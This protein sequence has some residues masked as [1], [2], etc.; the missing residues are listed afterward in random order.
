[1]AARRKG[2]S[3]RAPRKPADP[4][5]NYAR[6]VKGGKIL[7]G[8]PVHLA[9]E[10][11]LR[12]LKRKDLV[13]RPGRGLLV[14]EFFRDMLVLEDGS[15][16]DLLDFQQ[17][18][19]G[20]VFGWYS[21]DGTRRFRTAYVE[22]GKGSGKTPMA[23][24]IGLYGLMADGE[25]APE[26]Y[27]AA[28]DRDQARIVWQD[29]WRMVQASPEL[30]ELVMAPERGDVQIG[31]LT[32]PSKSATFRPVSSE[33]R[34][35]DGKRIHFGLIDELHEH[36][37]AI[38][39]DKIRAGTK[40]RRNALIFE[41]TNSGWDRTSVCWKHHD[42]SVKVLE[43]TIEN[44]SWFAYV[45]AL[46]E[47][48]EW[49]DE[50]VWSKANP[51]MFYGLPPIKYL[52]EQI[53]EA[54]GMPSK[55]NIVRRLNCC[56]WTEQADRWLKMDAW[57]ACP[58]EA[59]EILKGRPCMAA[60]DAAATG[61]INAFV[62]VFKP[63]EDGIYPVLARFWIPERTL[64]AKDSGRPEELRLKLLEWAR[65][66]WIK[67]TSGE[68]TDYDIVEEDIKALLA[69]VEL[70]RLSYDRWNVTQLITHLVD[71]LGEERVVAFPQTMAA[72]SAPSKEMER[73]I[74]DGK[75]GHGGNPVLAWM[76]SN[77]ALMYGPNEQVKPDRTRSGDKIDGIV[78]LVM[79]LDG[80][81]RQG[82][83][84]PDVY[85]ERHAA[86]KEMVDSW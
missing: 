81:M 65:A 76:A 55:E 58:S 68:Q 21:T 72:M 5:T 51:G 41:I 50:R 42:Y 73:L 13:W 26:V 64:D 40:R 71:A 2:V 48:D 31:S 60:L 14:I 79:A 46:D 12:D 78:A 7:A 35:L 17:F 18:I 9:C 43:G 54:V 83:H 23:A 56:E 19:V 67:T 16:F 24:G 52:R 39:V 69:E 22:T 25:P 11:H 32:I 15:P 70:K 29:A 59:V 30:R 85:E 1:M 4:V 3:K 20:S 82:E 84:V 62:L 66:G 44:D 75:L 10:R 6:R 80:W 36:P 57:Q 37:T 86:G 8:R 63:G 61:D 49:T 53:N 74:S 34:A 47:G 27:S 77:V 33:H 28:T 45:C 38:V